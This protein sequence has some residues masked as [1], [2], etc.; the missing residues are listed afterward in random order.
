[1][2]TPPRQ[3]LDV[4]DRP[5]I[6]SADEVKGDDVRWLAMLI[7]QGLK[8]VVVGIE[9]YYDLNENKDKEKAT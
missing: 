3:P 5:P 7:R 4:L 8:L 6:K 9:H 1:M 2:T